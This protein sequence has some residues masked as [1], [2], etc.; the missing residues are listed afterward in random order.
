MLD[1]PVT[2]ISSNFV[3]LLLIAT[4]SLT[5]HLILRYQELVEEK[6]GSTH[7]ELLALT[8]RDMWDPSLY[9]ALTTVVAFASL[10]TSTIPPIID[11]A[12]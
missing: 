5:I 10:I 12:G 9:T 7:E 2:V 11:S 4:V 6:P 8:L 3:S 1:W